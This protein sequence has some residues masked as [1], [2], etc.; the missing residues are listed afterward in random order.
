[1]NEERNT[2]S[3]RDV[4]FCLLFIILFVFILLWLFPSKAYLNGNYNKNNKVESNQVFNNNIN[5]MKDAAISY[6]TTS[7]LPKKIG[8]SVDLTLKQMRDKKLILSL[9]DSKGNACDEGMSYIEITKEK[10]EYILK[11][12]LSCS[13]Y[14]DYIL[15]H[16]G[17]YDYCENDVCEKQEN[18]KY[19]YMLETLCKLTDFGAF[20]NWSTQYISSNANRIVETKVD[21]I[22]T[23]MSQV[24][25]C[26]D[27]YIYNETT[28][29]CVKTSSVIDTKDAEENISYSCEVGYELDN[30]TN[31]CKK[32]L[33]TTTIVAAKENEKTYSCE[34]YGTGYTLNNENKS[35]VKNITSIDT[36]D[37]KANTTY[38]CEVG[39]TLNGTT[40]KKDIYG[41]QTIAASKKIDEVCTT[42]NETVCEDSCKVQKITTCE[43]IVTYY[44]PKGVKSGTNCTINNTYLRT[45]TKDSKSQTT[46]SCE[47]GYNLSGNK[48]TRELLTTDIK[49]AIA[50]PVTY[51]CENGY[52]LDG[53]MCTINKT[54][55]DTKKANMTS[56]Y[57]CAIFGSDY[58][59]NGTKCIRTSN[60][61]DTKD[62][63]VSNV[64]P[65]GYT[66]NN[67]ICE[68]SV[69]SYRYKTRSC[70]GGSVDYKW[71]ELEEDKDLLNKGYKLTGKKEL[72]AK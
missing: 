11:V 6:F 49:S 30:N 19:E 67:N 23:N 16:L 13:D 62:V 2:F 69:I 20:S 33:T 4:I 27:G 41:T 36:K 57:S 31:T 21:K 66:L 1:M 32:S 22:T 15:V 18:Y 64:C 38:S 9:I 61:V 70:T 68:A 5:T 7:R 44:C 56:S 59:I 65:S 60:V 55:V 46:Y 43:K 8:D 35:C 51:Y 48:C 71:S 54:I 53:S 25:S 39:Y 47:A 50:S 17:C 12:S 37:A 14:D 52:T 10:D 29:K 45:D 72:L 42:K 3:L 63:I 26:T 28:K 58:S 40:C 34:A 24:T